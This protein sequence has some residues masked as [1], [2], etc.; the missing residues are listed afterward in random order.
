MRTVALCLLVGVV[1]NLGLSGCAS[2]SEAKREQ[3]KTAQNQ[4]FGPYSARRLDRA[5]SHR[6]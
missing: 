1:T 4:M 3:V 5:A 6:N 2:P